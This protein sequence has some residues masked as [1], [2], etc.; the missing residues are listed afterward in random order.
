MKRTVLY[1]M[2]GVVVVAMV[3]GAAYW[4]S[5]RTDQSEEDIRSAVVERGTMLVAV[6]ASG[7]IEPQARV[8]LTFE[9]PGEVLEVPVEVPCHWRVGGKRW[10]ADGG[11]G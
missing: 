11:R 9:L 8:N 5:Q 4:R 6:S 7:S 3:A 2:L 10:I 1:V